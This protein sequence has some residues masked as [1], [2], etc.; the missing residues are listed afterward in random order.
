MNLSRPGKIYLGATLIAFGIAIL[1]DF[2]LLK[3][4]LYGLAVLLS[5]TLFL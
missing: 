4:A 1:A 5:V 2:S 3:A